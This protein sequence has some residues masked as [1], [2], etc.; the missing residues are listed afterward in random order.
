MD[1]MLLVDAVGLLVE[2][3][4]DLTKAKEEVARLKQ[5]IAESELGRKLAKAED[6]LRYEKQL[7]ADTRA[8]IRALGVEQ[9]EVT[10]DADLGFGLKIRRMKEMIYDED[11]VKE[12]AKENAP[13]LLMLNHKMF[14]GSFAKSLPGLVVVEER[15]VVTIPR[16]IVKRW[17]E[18]Q[19]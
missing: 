5:E 1:D 8:T 19:I 10:H 9:Y 6:T 2:T 18:G 15:P 14:Q 13:V 16:D 3:Q 11:Q 4:D 17:E 12:W 7:D